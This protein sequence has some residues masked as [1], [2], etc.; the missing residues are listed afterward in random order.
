[1]T[2]CC[3]LCPFVADFSLD[4]IKKYVNGLSNAMIS[5]ILKNKFEKNNEKVVVNISMVLSVN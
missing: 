5:S 1:M 4:S 3:H 2:V